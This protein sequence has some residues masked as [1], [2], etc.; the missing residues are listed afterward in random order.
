MDKNTAKWLHIISF[1]LVLVGAVNWGLVGIMNYN[2]VESL[3]MGMPGVVKLVYS[4]VGVSALYLAATHMN[5]CK[6][7]GNQKRKK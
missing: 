5:D 1:A 2:L 3:L 6:Y 4:L 7:C